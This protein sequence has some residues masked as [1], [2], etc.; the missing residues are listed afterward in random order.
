MKN[1]PKRALWARKTQSRDA[2]V[3]AGAVSAARVRVAGSTILAVLVALVFIGIVV[4]SMLRNTGSQSGASVGYGTVQTAAVTASSGIVATESFF[5]ANTGGAALTRLN[6]F[7]AAGNDA[8]RNERSFVIGGVRQKHKIDKEQ[9]FSSRITD[10]DRNQSRTAGFEIKSGKAEKGR[11]LKTARA[12]Y[13]VGNGRITGETKFP[14]SNAFSATENASMPNA[15]GGMRIFGHATFTDG[16]RIQNQD[17]VEFFPDDNDEGSL[18]VRGEASI[19][20]SARVNIGVNAFFDGNVTIQ[21]IP[22]NP[23]TEPLFAKNVGFNGNISASNRTIGFG[24]DVWFNGNFLNDGNS[25]LR[26]DSINTKFY[27]TNKIPMETAANGCKSCKETPPVT[28]VHSCNHTVTQSERIKGFINMKPE[29]TSG[30]W[31]ANIPDIPQKVGITTLEQRG[32][33][34]ISM[35]NLTGVDK[36]GKMFLD[37]ADDNVLSYNSLTGASLQ[38]FYDR[39]SNHPDYAQYYHNGHL[40]I[41]IPPSG[42]ACGGGEFNGKV[43]FNV[44]GNFN[45]NTNFY[46]SNPANPDASTLVYVGSSGSLQ[47]FGVGNDG[48]FSGLI[49]VDKNNTKANTFKWGNNTTLNGAVILKGGTLTWNSGSNFTEIHRDNNILKNY[50]F[51]LDGADVDNEQVELIDSS[52]GLILSPAA[53][54]FY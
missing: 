37:A 44:E 42:A 12:F 39:T 35:N 7:L 3:P 45:V 34:D 49:Y 31:G 41:R 14:G 48:N 8:E 26:G 54:Y 4:A 28:C 11:D 38:A 47:N 53:Y 46:T 2:Q 51:L 52:K 17:N 27:Y 13:R 33:P 32:E 1:V 20:N 30:Y 25:V 9:F 23:V 5:H 21:N 10:Y 15:N 22:N 16:F 19:G 40:L 29:S 50:G 43:I 36:A 18:Y 24:G 6:A